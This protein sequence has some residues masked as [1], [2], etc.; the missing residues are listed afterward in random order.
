MTYARQE[1]VFRSKASAAT[2]GVTLRWDDRRLVQALESFDRITNGQ[3]TLAAELKGY[4]D[5]EVIPAAKEMLRKKEPGTFNKTLPPTRVFKQSRSIYRRVADSLKAEIDP[6]TGRIKIGS[7]PFPHGVAGQ[8]QRHGTKRTIAQIVMRGMR[9]FVYTPAGKR[10]PRGRKP[11]K[12]LPPTVRSSIKF[13]MAKQSLGERPYGVYS[14]V[15]M[16]LKRRH[17]GF[18]GRKKFDFVAFMVEQ[19]SGK[20][21]AFM[22]DYMPKVIGRLAYLAGF[23]H[24]SIGQMSGAERVTDLGGKWRE[25]TKVSYAAKEWK[26]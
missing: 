15:P 9:P 11:L 6:A 16:S 10:A 20:N 17:P 19:V 3:K 24:P 2:V 5:N 14:S 22:S 18:T 13:G 25:F 23:E 8:R 1:A 26:D 21:S 4:M 12:R 7:F